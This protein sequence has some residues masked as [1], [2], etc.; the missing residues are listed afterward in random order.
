MT[1][2]VIVNNG[3][4]GWKVHQILKDLSSVPKW[5]GAGKDFLLIPAP[6]TTQLGEKYDPITRIF[7]H[8][9]PP[10]EVE[11]FNGHTPLMYFDEDAWVWRVDAVAPMYRAAMGTRDE[12]RS[13]D[14]R[15]FEAAQLAMPVETLYPGEKLWYLKKAKA[16]LGLEQDV[17][18][19]VEEVT[20]GDDEFLKEQ[21]AYAGGDK[22]AEAIEERRVEEAGRDLLIRG[23]IVDLLPPDPPPIDP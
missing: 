3:E 17:I 13:H 15:I 22:L 19:Y 23:L 7:T 14:T 9:P 18:D 5:P 16:L 1:I 10:P 11:D 8:F 2:A 12:I 4:Q 20:T 21:L 6:E